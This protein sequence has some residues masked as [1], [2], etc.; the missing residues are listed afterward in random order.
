ML[1]GLRVGCWKSIEVWLDQR[2]ESEKSAF[3]SSKLHLLQKIDSLHA[4]SDDE[5]VGFEE[6]HVDSV[7]NLLA[8]LSCQ[9]LQPVSFHQMNWTAFELT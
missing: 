6:D 7:P 1:F 5:S 8:C 2:S 9:Q 3:R 4:D